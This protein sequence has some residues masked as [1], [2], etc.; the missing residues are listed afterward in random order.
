MTNVRQVW[1]RKASDVLLGRKIVAVQYLTNEERDEMGWYSCPII[2]TLDDGTI[3]FPTA[4]DE[5][6]DAGAIHYQKTGDNNYI[7]PVI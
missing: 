6:N 5:G 3:I 4:D 1:T 2:I 7:I